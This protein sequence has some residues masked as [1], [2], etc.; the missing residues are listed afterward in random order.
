[1]KKRGMITP[2]E[3]ADAIGRPYQTIL[4]W[5]RNNMVPGVEVIEES[6]G[7]IYLVPQ[8]AVEQFK[9]FTPRRGRPPNPKSP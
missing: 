6:R 8:K 2:K 7:P 5:L 3:F 1:M 9:G 4:Y